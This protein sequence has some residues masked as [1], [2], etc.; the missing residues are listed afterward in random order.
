MNRLLSTALVLT[1]AASMSAYAA[2]KEAAQSKKPASGDKTSWIK[3]VDESKIFDK[4]VRLDVQLL[5]LE[6]DDKGTYITTAS[7]EYHAAIHFAN[8]DVEISFKI[9]GHIRLLDNGKVFVSYST[10]TGFDSVEGEGEFST[11]GS[12]ILNAGEPASVAFIG[13][14][15]LV[16]EVSFPDEAKAVKKK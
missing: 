3:V 9:W 1:L 11:S 6:D 7:P 4:N 13:E 15:T 16:L 2:E 8:D 10:F 12:V 14:K 5:P